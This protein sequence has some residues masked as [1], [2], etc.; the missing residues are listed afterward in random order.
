M[1][2]INYCIFSYGISG[3]NFFKKGKFVFWGGFL[4]YIGKDFDFVVYV[5]I[6]RKLGYLN[7]FLWFF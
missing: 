3:L 5:I 1:I 4:F 6:M 2:V 7:V